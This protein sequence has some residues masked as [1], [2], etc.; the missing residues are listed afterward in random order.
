MLLK[1]Q[2]VFTLCIYLAVIF[3]VLTTRRI[4]QTIHYHPRRTSEYCFQMC[5]V[6]LSETSLIFQILL[7]SHHEI[8]NTCT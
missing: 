4:D 8:M 2:P 1:L 5:V 6:C 7:D 3:N